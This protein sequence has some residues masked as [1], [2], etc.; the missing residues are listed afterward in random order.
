MTPSIKAAEVFLSAQ[1]RL[2]S[3]S[4]VSRPL[5]SLIQG[6]TGLSVTES[7][8]NKAA[9][10]LG[11]KG[12]YPRFN[13]GFAGGAILP[14]PS[15][16]LKSGVPVQLPPA[17]HHYRWGFGSYTL[18]QSLAVYQ[19]LSSASTG[20]PRTSTGTRLQDRLARLASISPGLPP[21]LTV[22]DALKLLGADDLNPYG[23]AGRA[24]GESLKSLGYTKEGG[25]YT[26]AVL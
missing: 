11:I 2:A 24:V 20:K 23:G 5:V 21:V 6:L 19:A 12:A 18:E 10:N 7:D 26:K 1:N 22:A 14:D 4:S 25:A 9:R 8:I 16:F 15:D 17:D 3:P 13:L